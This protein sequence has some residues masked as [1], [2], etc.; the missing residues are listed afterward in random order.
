MQKIQHGLVITLRVAVTGIIA[1]I[2]SMYIVTA[3]SE[4]IVVALSKT[5]AAS[6]QTVI[7]ATAF[8]GGLGAA[9]VWLIKYY[10]RLTGWLGQNAVRACQLVINAAKES[11]ERRASKKAESDVNETTTV[12]ETEIEKTDD[13]D[14]LSEHDVDAENKAEKVE[15][16][17]DRKE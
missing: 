16:D 4:M 15:D 17:C 7:F 8:I 3:G 5:G 13:D 1:L 12:T 10:Y 6:P 2:A 14:E 9:C 11:K